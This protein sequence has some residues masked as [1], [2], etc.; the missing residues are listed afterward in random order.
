MQPYPSWEKHLSMG[1]KVQKQYHYRRGQTSEKAKG[2]MEALTNIKIA[3][4]KENHLEDKLIKD[5]Q[6]HIPS[7]L[8]GVFCGTPK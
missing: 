5:D 4:I 2:Y 8:T 7:K 1:P 6:D 3:V